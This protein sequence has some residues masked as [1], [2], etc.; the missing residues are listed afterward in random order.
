MRN[1]AAA[2]VGMAEVG[3]FKDVRPFQLALKAI[4]S[5]PADS[6]LEKDE[7]E[8]V[9]R[10]K[11]G[12]M[13]DNYMFAHQRMAE[14]LGLPARSAGEVDCG[15][16]SSLVALRHVAINTSGGRLSLEHPRVRDA[17]VR[18]V[19]GGDAASRGSGRPPGAGCPP[20]AGPGGARHGQRKRG[21]HNGGGLMPGYFAAL[22]DDASARF[23]REPESDRLMTTR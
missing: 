17:L 16:A 23:Y 15:E 8:A 5:A 18:D 14:Y 1:V 4:T 2:V 10:T 6:R 21:I 9:L 12:H 13:V 20:R 11:T 19:R 7:I 22:E 3:I